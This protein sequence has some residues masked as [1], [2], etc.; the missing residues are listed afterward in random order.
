MTAASHH[1]HEIVMTVPWLMFRIGVLGFTG[2][3]DLTPQPRK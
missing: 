2:D 3:F 1:A